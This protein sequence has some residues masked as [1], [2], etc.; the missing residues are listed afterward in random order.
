MNLLC[1]NCQKMLTVPEQYAGQ[2]MKCPLCSGNFTVPALPGG[3]HVDPAPAFAPAPAAPP[4]PSAPS[5][6]DAYAVKFEPELAPAPPK[7]PVETPAFSTAPPEQAFSFAT[8]PAAPPKAPATSSSSGPSTP[9]APPPPPGDYTRK[10]AICFSD[11]VLQWVPPGAILLIFFLTWF[12]W[13]GVY[14]GGVAAVTQNA[15]QAAVGGYSDY[16][17]MKST[18][19]VLTEDDVK[20]LNESR[21]DKSGTKDVITK[22]GWNFLTLFYLFPFL[23]GSLVVTLGVAALPFLQIKLPPQVQQLLPWRWAIVTGLNGILLLFLGLQLPLSFNLESKE[24]DWV[25][26]QPEVKKEPKNNE[27]KCKIEA[28]QGDRERW[29]LRTF[30]FRL[31]VLLHILA[32]ASAA[33]VYWIEKRGPS[34]PLPR[35]ELMW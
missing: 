31:V 24:K 11:K 25:D 14:P 17:D 30:W 26:N 21:V 29:L 20:K 23:M 33:L 1:P 32:T 19:P 9:P 16:I 8:P 34:R 15:W 12:P 13:V 18:Y 7:P 35:L 2:L 28:F 6:P 3:P 10:V 4:P 27:E 22:P 5:L